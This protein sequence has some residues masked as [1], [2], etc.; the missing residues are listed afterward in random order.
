MA[1]ASAGGLEL[2]G[3]PYRYE[4]VGCGSRQIRRNSTRP[5]V[6]CNGCGDGYRSVVD[7]KRGERIELR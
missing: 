1:V 5:T 7:L 2:A 3:E 6:Y 4:C